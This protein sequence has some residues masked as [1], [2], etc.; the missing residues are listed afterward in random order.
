MA[1]LVS[2]CIMDKNSTSLYKHH[3]VAAWQ[4]TVRRFSEDKRHP[5]APHL[6]ILFKDPLLLHL[7]FPPLLSVNA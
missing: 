3:T 5:R 1:I 6:R 7:S 2:D 4:R